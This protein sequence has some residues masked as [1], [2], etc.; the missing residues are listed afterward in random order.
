MRLSPPQ[1]IDMSPLRVGTML[2]TPPGSRTSI[3]Y[4]PDMTTDGYAWVVE[5][6]PTMLRIRERAIVWGVV[7]AT[8]D[9]VFRLTAPGVVDFS[10]RSTAFGVPMPTLHK[11][12]DLLDAGEGWMQLR[13]ADKPNERP[14]MFRVADGALHVDLAGPMGTHDTKVEPIFQPGETGYVAPPAGWL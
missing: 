6:T 10:V 4:L 8:F 11:R 5:S 14:G 2:R 3:P 12:Y 13:S 9:Q 7:R 1:Q